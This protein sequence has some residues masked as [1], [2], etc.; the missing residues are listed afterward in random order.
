M[1]GLEC[2]VCMNPTIVI[3]NGVAETDADG[4][5]TYRR[6]R[7]CT[8]PNCQKFRHR[9]ETVEIFLPDDPAEEPFLVS[10]R[11][12]KMVAVAEDDPWQPPLFS[13]SSK[14]PDL[15]PNQPKKS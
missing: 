7:V 15:P 13:G 3:D 9:R 2:D 6:Y 5:V 4:R 11:E 10:P 1:A 8:N 14:A 12:L